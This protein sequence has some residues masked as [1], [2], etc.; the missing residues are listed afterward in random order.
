MSMPPHINMLGLVGGE[1]DITLMPLTLTSGLLLG[2]YFAVQRFGEARRLLSHTNPFLLVFLGLAT[3][4]I[5]W[6]AFPAITGARDYRLY[7]IF[8]ICFGFGVTKWDESKFERTIRPGLMFIMVGSIIYYFLSPDD[9]LMDAVV[10]GHVQ[11][12][13]LGAWKGISMHKNTLGAISS[14]AVI[15]YFHAVISRSGS[16]IPSLLGLVFSIICLLKSKSSTSLFAAIFAIAIITLILKSPTVKRR[17]TIRVFSFVL[18]VM[19]LVYS[20][21]VLNIVPGLS[22][23]VEPI[24]AM[25]GKDMTF[26]GR[27]YIWDIMKEEI[28]KHPYL[29]AGYASFWLGSDPLAPSAVFMKRLFFDPSESH[30]GYLDIIN[31]LGLVG[32][33]ALIGYIVTFLRQSVYLL[34]Y[35]RQKAALFIGLLFAQLIAN[36]SEAHWWRMSSVDFYIITL[37]TFDLARAI[38]E[39]KR[40]KLPLVY[41]ST[42][43]S[44]IGR[45]KSA[46]PQP[47]NGPTA[48]PIQVN[49][50]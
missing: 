1:L 31:E 6:S 30:N 9:A 18:M 29:G 2:V 24:V 15:F 44:A 46:I 43:Y 50:Q 45:N 13:L 39:S 49:R 32:A 35:N 36:M 28:T 47:N 34:P 7:A 16:R 11:M 4:S 48:S 8:F 21:G 19:F 37:A 38:L 14:V 5:L 17:R 23:I 40:M 25:T 33:L 12:E 20:L 42:Q 22:A 27:T 10:N 26:S 3:L 41:G